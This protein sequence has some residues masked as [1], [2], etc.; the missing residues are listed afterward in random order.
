MPGSDSAALLGTDPLPTPDDYAAY[1]AT[2]VDDAARHPLA[3]R[4][5]PV[6]TGLAAVEVFDIS[7]AGADGRRVS[8]WLRLPRHR[9][10]RLPAVVHFNGYGAGRL[11]PID[12]LTWPVA[13]L[14]QL[15]MNTH[16]QSGGSTGHLLD[17]IEDPHRSYYRGVFVDAARAVDALRSLDEVDGERVAAIGNSQGGGIALGVGA[18]QP[19]LAAVL[20][21]APFLTDAPQGIR[22]ARTGPWLELR[23]YLTE[24][25]DRSDAVARTLAYVDGVTSAR[26]ATAPG[27]ISDGLEDD[28]CP[29][30]TARAAAEA[31]AAPVT[32]RE[33]P[34]AG[35]EAGATADRRGALAVLRGRLGLTG[36]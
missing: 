30:E 32:L 17:G 3:V 20:A 18:L 23:A 11:D 24:H 7:F 28:I 34:G 36:A 8:G 13:G 1:W 6:D 25:P 19:T 5:E 21:Q 12:D 4:R 29:P 22:L 27:W 35:H 26:H 2:A 33:W 9:E 15:V 14:A 31:Y 16:G 10:G